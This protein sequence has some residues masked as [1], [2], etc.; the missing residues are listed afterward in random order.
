[1]EFDKL[2]Y[3]F[4]SNLQ[5]IMTNINDETKN[6]VYEIRLRS[7]KPII[8][9]TSAGLKFLKRNGQVTCHCDSDC[10]SIG[11]I[12]MEV[13][14]SRLCEQSLYSYENTI[15]NGYIPLRNG[16]RAG[17]CGD[18]SDVSY[19]LRSV[20]SIN[21]RIARQICG[22]EEHTFRL[23]NKSPK[24]VIIAGPPGSGKTTVLREL[25]RRFSDMHYCVCLL[26]ERGELAGMHESKSV[27][28]IG[29][30]TDVIAFRNK[31]ES[32][33]MAIKYLCPNIIVF[34]EIADDACII[35]RCVATGVSVFTTMHAETL[36]DV[37]TRLKLLGINKSFFNIIAVLNNEH[38]GDV[39]EF[40]IDGV[41]NA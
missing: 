5:Y 33:D 12:E 14:F 11:V 13:I 17:V 36:G 7:D 8:L 10:I 18:F 9:R 24:S 41:N 35:N 19:N 31:V 22:C 2:L 4:P 39:R 38:F 23:M 32:A 3:V 27:F 21:L 1:M 25:S 15:K 16:C 29:M 6:S 26:D 37:Y 20:S 30:N 40:K 28:D 34:D